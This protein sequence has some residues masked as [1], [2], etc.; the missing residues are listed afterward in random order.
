MDMTP[1]RYKAHLHGIVDALKAG[2][3]ALALTRFWAA[4]E[5]LTDE[6]ADAMMRFAAR[7]VD[8]A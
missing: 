8:P 1:A 6:Q 2:D 7:L 5:E 3:E 4:A